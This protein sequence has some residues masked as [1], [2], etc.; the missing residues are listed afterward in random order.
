MNI[1]VNGVELLMAQ[2]G[3]N[4][5][6]ERW[7]PLLDTNSIR[8]NRILDFEIPQNAVNDGVFGNV[9]NPQVALKT[10]LLPCVLRGNGGV[11]ERGFLQLKEIRKRSYVVS[12]T[13]G[14]GELFGEYTD[15]KLN[16]LD[17]GSEAV[18]GVF[19]AD[20]VVGT[21]KYCW[22]T[23]KNE[24][25]YGQNAFS[26]YMNNYVAGSYT[27]TPM[28][29]VL[30]VT[31]VL[32]LIGTLTGVSF[33]GT[34]M[35][36]ATLKRLILP[37]TASL[38]GLTTISYARHLPE[39][40]VREFVIGLANTF[41]AVLWLNAEKKTVTMDL[42]DGYFERGFGSAGFG[43]A[44]PTDWSRKFGR[45]VER[46]PLAKNRL[47]LEWTIDSND[48]L[49]KDVP[50]AF[51][52]YLTESALG[53]PTGN[54]DVWNVKSPFCGVVM[55]AGLPAVSMEGVSENYNQLSKKFGARLAFWNGLLSGVPQASDNYGGKYLRLRSDTGQDIR[56]GYWVNMEKWLGRTYSVAAKTVLNA[57]EISLLDMHRRKGEVTQIY[58]QGDYFIIGHQRIQRNGEWTGEL[59]RV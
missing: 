12:Y 19:V 32:E 25:F 13:A 59:W 52:P 31:K 46:V 36:N 7:N 11:A 35:T 42:A 18:P 4:F 20:P 47:Q 23:M 34:F 51:Q 24:A 33:E 10:E 8:G 6:L 58:A 38:D 50:E 49:L 48:G 45:L 57:Y 22:P 17:L 26:G 3:A 37:N 44:Q 14:F 53:S 16:E 40:T 54:A 28:V 56:S 2:G 5:T 29:P 39:L 41:N 1:V 30:F 27:G 43:S 9:N 55:D 15:R 21:A